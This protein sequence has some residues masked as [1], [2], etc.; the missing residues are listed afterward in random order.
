MTHQLLILPLHNM[1]TWFIQTKKALFIGKLFAEHV[2]SSTFGHVTYLHPRKITWLSALFLS[3]FWKVP[4]SIYFCVYHLDGYSLL[5]FCYHRLDVIDKCFSHETVE[6]IVDALVSYDSAAFT[7]LTS[8]SV[9]L[10]W[11]SETYLLASHGLLW[12]YHGI[13]S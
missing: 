10:I 7:F 12:N 3:L 13:Y 1:E 11:S 4:V 2:S 9:W 6:E 5:H 8:I